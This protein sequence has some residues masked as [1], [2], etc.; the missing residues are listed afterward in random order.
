MMGDLLIRNVPDAL[1]LQLET[2]ARNSRK[3]L[4]AKAIDLFRTGLAA[5]GREDQVGS[6]SG[7][8][9]LRPLFEDDGGA[10]G[11]YSDVL[12]EIELQRKREFGRAPDT[13]ASGDPA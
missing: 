5:E 11:K 8:D 10:D 1:K 6:K 4:S 7:W 12:D 3:S 2:S 13:G 9:L